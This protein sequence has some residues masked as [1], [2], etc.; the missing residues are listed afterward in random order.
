MEKYRKFLLLLSPKQRSVILEIIEKLT[1]L[2]F[3]GMD[4]KKLKG[5]DSLYRV[6]KGSVRIVYFYNGEKVV[7]TDIAFRKDA[8]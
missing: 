6:R 1:K 2:D 3:V 4:I 5:Y 7:V 8:Y